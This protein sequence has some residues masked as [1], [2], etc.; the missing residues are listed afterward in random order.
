MITG[1]A[2]RQCRRHG[3]HEAC[4]EEELECHDAVGRTGAADQAG[5]GCK[6]GKE[7]G[8]GQQGAHGGPDPNIAAI[9]AS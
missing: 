6:G 3:E 7:R 9:G 2:F 1:A 5:E 8:D 4:H